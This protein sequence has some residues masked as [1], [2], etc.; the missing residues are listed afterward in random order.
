MPSIPA[1]LLRAGPYVRYSYLALVKR[2]VSPGDENGTREEE[3]SAAREWWKGVTYGV[4]ETF[5]DI[6]LLTEGRNGSAS[7]NI[8]VGPQ[9]ML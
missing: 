8:S 2:G 7:M 4:S 5:L 6:S 9:K 3:S 1:R